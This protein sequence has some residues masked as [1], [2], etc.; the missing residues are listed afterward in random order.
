MQASD[1]AQLITLD[2]RIQ[3]VEQLWGSV[4]GVDME[5]VR[6][7][8]ASS[9]HKV[10]MQRQAIGLEFAMCGEI[11][12]SSLIDVLEKEIEEPP[13]KFRDPI[14]LT[15]MNDPHVVSSGHMFD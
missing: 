2:L 9:L 5:E 13:E 14:M 11:A 12:T 10:P 4:S 8:A 15:L 6:A 1:V 3:D 7:A